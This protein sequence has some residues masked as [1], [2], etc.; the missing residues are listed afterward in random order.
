[1]RYKDGKLWI[2]LVI[3]LYTMDIYCNLGLDLKVQQAI[4]T[5]NI[6][7]NGQSCNKLNKTRSS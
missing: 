1:M 5:T 3:G 6:I 2:T 7:N 4:Y